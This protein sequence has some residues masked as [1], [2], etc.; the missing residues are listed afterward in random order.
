MIAL[1]IYAILIV[2]SGNSIVKSQRQQ[3]T[4]RGMFPSLIRASSFYK[5]SKKGYK[6]ASQSSTVVK[7]EKFWQATGHINLA[8]AWLTATKTSNVFFCTHI[9]AVWPMEQ[10]SILSAKFDC[11]VA[12]Q[13]C[14]LSYCAYL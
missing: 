10:S 11:P 13:N 2:L 14:S 5:E 9:S 4:T 7:S 3:F 12:H 6:P 1:I 8:Y